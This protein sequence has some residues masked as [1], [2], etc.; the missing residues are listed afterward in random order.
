M[1]VAPL[2]AVGTHGTAMALNTAYHPTVA[3][4]EGATLSLDGG[5][6]ARHRD[7]PT[8]GFNSAPSPAGAA[9]A[10]GGTVGPTCSTRCSAPHL[11]HLQ[12]CRHAAAAEFVRPA[13]VDLPQ[14]AGADPSVRRGALDKPGLDLVR[15]APTDAQESPPGL[16]HVQ[17]PEL[18]E[19]ATAQPVLGAARARDGGDARR[20]R[21]GTRPSRCPTR[22]SSPAAARRDLLLG[23]ALDRA[24]LPCAMAE[25]ARGMV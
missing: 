7:C 12:P 20:G 9:R 3:A 24:G 18:Q 17:T 25:T 4:W 23:L 16:A 14:Q 1:L 11:R 10:G 13:V 2:S 21:S 15:W 8:T 19:G 5:A 22:S 6:A